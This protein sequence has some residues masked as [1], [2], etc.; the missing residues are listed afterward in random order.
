MAGE[1]A[2][3]DVLVVENPIGDVK[4]LPGDVIVRPWRE[5]VVRKISFR[6]SLIMPDKSRA[7]SE[8]WIGTVV[9]VGEPELHKSGA[10]RIPQ[11]VKV[12]DTVLYRKYGGNLIE[13]G[14]EQRRV[15][16]P[17]NDDILSTLERSDGTMYREEDFR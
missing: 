5:D 12:G 15:L 9:D 13:W 14:R 10:F 16:R 7:M 4:A 1:R 6:T 17:R 11:P 8:A 2:K 3:P